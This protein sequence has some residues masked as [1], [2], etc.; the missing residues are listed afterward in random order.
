M[1]RYIFIRRL[2]GPAFLM[3]VG[4]IA[5]LAQA[6]I[7]SW[8]KSWPL[9]L[10]LAG[11]LLLA[12]R[13]ALAAD[14]PP[15]FPDQYPGQYPGQYPAQNPGLYPGQPYSAATDP[16]AAAQQ[17]AQ[18][19]TAIVPAHSHDFDSDPNRDRGQS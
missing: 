8:G 19:G 4:V 9:Y 5:L 3:L 1:N 2:R 14:G 16:L 13:A 7:I 12:E 18:S 15:P 17:P 6:H 10:I 11:V